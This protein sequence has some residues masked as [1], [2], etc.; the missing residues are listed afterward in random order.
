MTLLQHPDQIPEAL[1]CADGAPQQIE[2]RQPRSGM[3][4]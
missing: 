2:S 4:G 1:G 3:V